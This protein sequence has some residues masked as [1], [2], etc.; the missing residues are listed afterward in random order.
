MQ[1]GGLKYDDGKVRWDLLPMGALEEVARVYT[2]GVKKYDAWNWRK[3]LLFSQCAAAF[4]RHWVAWWWK[5]ERVDPESGCHPLAA[6]VFYL[7]NFMTYEMDG[8]K[9]CD[10]R[11]LNSA[12]PPSPIRPQIAAPE[13]PT[14]EIAP[15]CEPLSEGQGA[16]LPKWG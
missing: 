9:E 14:Q 3:G 13:I 12:A 16:S 8:R 5:G 1:P 4:L 2:F 15:S 6:C 11:Q 7:L 10:D